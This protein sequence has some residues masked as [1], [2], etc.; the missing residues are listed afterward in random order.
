VV[1]SRGRVSC[2]RARSGCESGGDLVGVQGGEAHWRGAAASQ[3]RASCCRSRR[4]A[5]P[6]PD[7]GDAREGDD[8]VH[9]QQ[10]GRGYRDIEEERRSPVQPADEGGP[11]QGADGEATGEQ[12]TVEPEDTVALG[13]PRRSRWSATTAPR[14]GASRWRALQRPSG[15]QQY[16][17][18]RQPAQQRGRDRQRHPGL[19]QPAPPEQ[20]REAAEDQGEA[21]RRQDERRGHPGQPGQ[22]QP[23]S[24]TDLRHG[25]VQ[26]RE[27]PPVRT[28][29]PD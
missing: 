20:I 13:A 2:P 5:E 15:Q 10:D 3:G 21:G 27:A 6:G 1:V 22:P 16:R 29:R 8:H 19:E 9:G 17:V 24:G 28:A 23:D 4:A 18:R 7:H 25:H 26:D 12:R 11:G 14:A